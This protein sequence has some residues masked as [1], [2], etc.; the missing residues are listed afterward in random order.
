[1]GTRNNI[2]LWSMETTRAVLRS[3]DSLLLRKVSRFDSRA[4]GVVARS[5][6]NQATCPEKTRLT[7]I[8]YPCFFIYKGLGVVY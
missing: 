1:M 3:S 4:G 8:D 2:F 5:Q 6:E 7:E